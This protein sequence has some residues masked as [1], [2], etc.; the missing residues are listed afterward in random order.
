MHLNRMSATRRLSPA[1]TLLG[2]KNQ[3]IWHM[4]GLTWHPAV[5]ILD[6]VLGLQK[7]V[8]QL[9]VGWA[10]DKKHIN[11]QLIIVGDLAYQ[12][13]NPNYIFMSPAVDTMDTA[14]PSFPAHCQVW[15]KSSQWAG[16]ESGAERKQAVKLSMSVY[17]KW[18][19]MNE[20]NTHAWQM[21]SQ[22]WAQVYALG[23]IVQRALL[24]ELLPPI[25]LVGAILR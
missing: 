13:Q 8:K 12:P 25:D 10:P 15:R 21:L 9:Y 4:F 18:L 7:I 16:L 5:V 2:R 20:P 17:Q 6:Q 11:N 19:D 3:R 22:C 14:P 1:Q 23:N 24:C